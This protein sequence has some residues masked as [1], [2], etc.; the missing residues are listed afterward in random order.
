MRKAEEKPAVPTNGHKPALSGRPFTPGH[1]PRRNVTKPGPGR[2]PNW[3]AAKCGEIANELVLPECERYLREHTLADDAA[4]WRWAAQYV[5][6]YGKGR[7]VQPVD[8][9]ATVPHE[10]ALDALE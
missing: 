10:E 6:D 4:A 8:L 2:P 9:D 5:T 7:P 1:D 3:F